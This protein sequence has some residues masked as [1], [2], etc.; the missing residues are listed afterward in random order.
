MRFSYLFSAVKL[1][2][3]ILNFKLLRITF[4]YI[5][6]IK[7]LIPNTVQYLARYLTIIFNID[8][9]ANESYVNIT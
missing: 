3:A 1:T 9:N 7:T 5:I 4:L 2:L 8:R 6:A